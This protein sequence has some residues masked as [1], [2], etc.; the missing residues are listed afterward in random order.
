MVGKDT[1]NGAAP[2][3][4]CRNFAWD[5]R[6]GSLLLV[7]DG[8]VFRRTRPEAPGGEWLSANVLLDR[9]PQG[10]VCFMPGARLQIPM[11]RMPAFRQ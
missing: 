7:S 4:D 1:K 11:A 6:S 2:H 10:D 8:G 5:H 3:C 9:I